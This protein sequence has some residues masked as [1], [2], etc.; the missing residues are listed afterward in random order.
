MLFHVE[1]TGVEREGVGIEVEEVERV[2]PGWKNL[3]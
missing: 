2:I 3:G 1:W